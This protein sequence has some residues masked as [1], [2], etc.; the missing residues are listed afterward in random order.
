MVTPVTVGKA[1]AGS[2]GQKAVPAGFVNLF[3][4]ERRT[5]HPVK[6]RVR[7]GFC[8]MHDHPVDRLLYEQITFHGLLIGGGELGDG[9]KYGTAAVVPRQPLESRL[10]HGSGARGVKIAHI[11]IK[12]GKH[13]HGLFD[14]GR[15][16]VQL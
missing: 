5:N 9:D 13:P 11:N 8:I 7:G 2:D 3:G 15:Y 16:V 12:T 14:R 10:H 1:H 6:T 4:L